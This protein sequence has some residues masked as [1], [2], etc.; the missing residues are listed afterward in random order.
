MGNRIGAIT[1]VAT[2]RPTVA[3]I[4]PASCTMPVTMVTGRV[5]A[6]SRT[7]CRSSKNS[8]RSKSTSGTF[9]ATARIE[10]R[11]IR[12]TFSPSS[13]CR[14]VMLLVSR[15][16]AAVANTSAPTRTTVRDVLPPP[17]DWLMTS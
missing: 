17:R 3:T 15:L 9:V 2:A 5:T 12:C 8:G 11:L 10:A 14:S 7:R 6:L 4:P 13:R 16:E 1:A